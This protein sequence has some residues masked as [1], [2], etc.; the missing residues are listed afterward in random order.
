[1]HEFKGVGE[2][3]RIYRAQVRRRGIALSSPSTVARR[4]GIS[5][6]W[7]AAGA[8]A[9]IVLLA[10]ATAVVLAV[11]REEDGSGETTAPA[12][13]TS[14]LTIDGSAVRLEVVRT[15]EESAA[16]QRDD[17]TADGSNGILYDGLEPPATSDTS[18]YDDPV[19]L[20]WLDGEKQVLEVQSDVAGNDEVVVSPPGARYTLELSG[21]T[22]SRLGI[23][24]GEA[25]NVYTATTITAAGGELNAEVACL[26]KEMREIGH[27]GRAP[28]PEDGGLLYNWRNGG[29]VGWSTAGYLFA[30][31]IVWLDEQKTVI[32][33]LPDVQPGRTEIPAPEAMYYAIETNAGAAERFGLTTGA[34]VA[35]DVP[36][37]PS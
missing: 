7:V 19:D 12:L 30:I 11:G 31:D 34:V 10:T 21:G 36:C 35:F 22:A 17:R 6:N 28:L 33:V 13:A 23:E 20:V 8:F 16:V 26:E 24:V 29:S 15:E 3:M 18:G 14:L 25:I 9:A 4:G 1:V 27:V 5:L 2:P 37:D 32:D